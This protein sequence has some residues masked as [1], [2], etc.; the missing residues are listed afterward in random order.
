MQILI[1]ILG[2][3]ILFFGRKLFWLYIATLGFLVG[4]ELI[5]IV[6]PSEPA[7]VLITGGLAAGLI[8]SVLAIFFQ[9]VAFGIAGFFAGAY[10]GALVVHIA[11]MGGNSIIGFI[12]GGL[13]GA[14]AA[15][16]L[17][18]WAII[19]FSSFVGAGAIVTQIPLG[20]SARALIF[21]ALVITGIIVQTRLMSRLKEDQ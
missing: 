15:L 14:I 12:V 2:I 10:L 17:M 6:S 3:A 5:K 18:N 8:G 21:V 1:I 4:V 9:R 11:G 20:Q 16:L 7:W 13:I 19:V